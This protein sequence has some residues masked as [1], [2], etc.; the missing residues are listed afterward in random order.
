MKN[1]NRNWDFKLHLID[2]IDGK[3]DIIFNRFCWYHC[4][5]GIGFLKSI[6][7]HLNDSGIFIGVLHNENRL[8]KSRGLKSLMI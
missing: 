6:V 1:S 4:L 7:N 3:Y 5:D 2:N 8:G